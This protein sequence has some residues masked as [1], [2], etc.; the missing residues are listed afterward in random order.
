MSQQVLFYYR[1]SKSLYNGGPCVRHSVLLFPLGENTAKASVEVSRVA[2]FNVL[3]VIMAEAQLDANVPPFCWGIGSHSVH[4]FKMCWA[5]VKPRG[6]AIRG[7][8]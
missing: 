8:G 4:E 7:L 5:N 6:A 2:S 3:Q 1:C